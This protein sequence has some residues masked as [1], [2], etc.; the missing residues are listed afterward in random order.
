MDEIDPV[1]KADPTRFSD[2]EAAGLEATCTSESVP[3]ERSTWGASAT[4]PS[5]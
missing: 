3:M 1:L 2:A 5:C 4:R